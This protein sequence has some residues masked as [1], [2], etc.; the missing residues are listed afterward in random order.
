MLLMFSLSS[1]Q[2]VYDPLAPFQVT[3]CPVPVSNKEQPRQ[4]YQAKSK[5][6]IRQELLLRLL[7]TVPVGAGS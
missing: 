6:H 3:V 4:E 2:P 5:E 7:S 1:S